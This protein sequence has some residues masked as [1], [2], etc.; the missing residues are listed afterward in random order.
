MTDVATLNIRNVPESVVATLK[1]R[2]ARSGDSLNT[3]VVRTLTRAAERRTVEEIL[4]EIDR[5]RAGIEPRA[6]W[7]GFLDEL[8]AEREERAERIGR[9]A[10]R[11]RRER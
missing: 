9:A 4:A 1:G 11:P 2:A 6:D 3:E 5:L 8:R 10:T 7:Q